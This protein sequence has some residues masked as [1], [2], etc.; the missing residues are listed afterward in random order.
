MESLRKTVLERTS[1]EAMRKADKKTKMTLSHAAVTLAISRPLAKI[2]RSGGKGKKGLK[3]KTTTATYPQHHIVVDVAT[4]IKQGHHPGTCSLYAH[5]STSWHYCNST[6]ELH[7]NTSKQHPKFCW[8][9]FPYSE[10][11]AQQYH[12]LA[13]YVR[14]NVDTCHA[15]QISA[16]RPNLANHILETPQRGIIGAC[17]LIRHWPNESSQVVGNSRCSMGSICHNVFYQRE[18]LFLK[19]VTRKVHEILRE[20]YAHASSRWMCACSRIDVSTY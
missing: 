2:S 15:S 7:F 1:A 6:Y 13:S 4:C 12:V 11:T 20:I 9:R 19:P 14:V 5:T 8:W 18:Q 17:C 16:A 10:T 3:G